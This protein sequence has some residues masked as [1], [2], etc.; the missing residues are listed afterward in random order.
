MEKFYS[1]IENVFMKP[2]TK[3]AEQR[4]LKAIRDGMVSTI[5]LTI[6]GSFFLI[7]AFP[8]VPASWKETMGLFLWI[9]KNIGDILIPFRITMGLVAIYATYNIGYSLAKNYKLDGVS[10]GTLSLVAYFMTIVP[11]IA[12]SNTG[13]GL[14]FV[15][16]M[17]KLGGAGLF[18]G[19]VTAIFAVETLRFFKTK[20]ITIKMP[21]GVPDSVARSFEALFPTVA[22][23]LITW[24]LFVMLKLDIH[25][26]F[27]SI[28]NPLKGIVDTPIGAIIMVMLITMLW[29]AGIHGVSVIGA[30]ARPI[31]LEMLTANADAMQAGEKVLPYITPEPFFQWFVWI[32]GSGGTLGLVFLLLFAKSKYLKDLGRA[33]ILPA[34]FNINEP[35]IFGLPIMLNPFFTIPF[36]LGPVLATIITYSAMALNLVSRPAILAPWTFPAPI[37]AY[38]ATGGDIRA[39]FLC[40]FNIILMGAVYYPF[41]KAYDKK[42]SVEENEEVI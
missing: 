20:G 21:E 38:L 22:V 36:I 10:G 2:M 7:V 3:L 12:T 9:Q 16:P 35:I 40:I 23:V 26:I 41:L 34:I 18:V 17:S 29:T 27:Q 15:L 5:P 25:N 31:W 19:I 33:T 39:V 42:M 6:V 13:E 28:F 1:I 14:G 30:I 11:S 37:G 8:P 24:F 4:H 32:G